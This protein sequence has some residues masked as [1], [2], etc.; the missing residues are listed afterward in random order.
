VLIVMSP[1]FALLAGRFCSVSGAIH[2]G[3]DGRVGVTVWVMFPT[4]RHGR[5]RGGHIIGKV[6][7]RIVKTIRPR[8]H[9]YTRC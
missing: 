3:T 5:V 9:I 8:L 4:C 7:G 1:F 2:L 6:A